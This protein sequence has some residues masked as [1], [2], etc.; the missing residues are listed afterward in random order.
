MRD[1]SS[2]RVA[3]IGGGGILYCTTIYILCCHQAWANADFPYY[4]RLSF[5]TGLCFPCLWTHS[6]LSGADDLHMH[7]WHE[8]A[9]ENS[10]S[11]NW[12][13]Y[14]LRRVPC[15]P[16]HTAQSC[17]TFQDV[18]ATAVASGAAHHSCSESSSCGCPIQPANGLRHQ[19]GLPVLERLADAVAL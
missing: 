15:K 9:G 1:N 8:A 4:E 6:G 7:L 12:T 16:T 10:L 3:G 19:S 17:A 5:A 11:R 2:K 18:D 13:H 14:Y